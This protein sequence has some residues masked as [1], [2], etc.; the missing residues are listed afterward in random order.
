[1]TTAQIVN[2]C[3]PLLSRHEKPQTAA[4]A[5]SFLD[6]P[7]KYWAACRKIDESGDVLL[8]SDVS[9]E[10][11]VANMRFQVQTRDLQSLLH[12]LNEVDS[13]WLI[14]TPSV[15][16]PTCTGWGRLDAWRSMNWN[17]GVAIVAEREGPAERLERPMGLQGRVRLEDGMTMKWEDALGPGIFRYL[18]KAPPYS[19]ETI[20]C[21][22]VA[23]HG[24]NVVYAR[25]GGFSYGSGSRQIVFRA[26]HLVVDGVD[27]IA[28]KGLARLV[29]RVGDLYGFFTSTPEFLD[30]RG[31]VS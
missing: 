13:W 20:V 1:M 17:K 14:N 30:E 16:S 21:G 24:G 8:R 25:S 15:A 7:K 11:G 27:R 2:L 3:L 4:A 18:A 5:T 28:L 26:L 9:V 22:I 6:K 29:G 23:L 31:S 10:N 19:M 12:R